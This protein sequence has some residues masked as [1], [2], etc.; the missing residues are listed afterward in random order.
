[1][2]VC[3]TSSIDCESRQ[4][5]ISEITILTHH[6]SSASSLSSNT[7]QFLHRYLSTITEDLSTTFFKSQA[8]IAA[9]S[10]ATDCL[11]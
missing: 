1:M 10:Q 3:Y 7:F 11:Q 2:T 5:N 9:K 6:L 4:K 8:R